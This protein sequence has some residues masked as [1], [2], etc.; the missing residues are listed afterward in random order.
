MHRLATSIYYNT[1]TVTVRQ[2]TV[3]GVKSTDHFHESRYTGVPGFRRV[4][5]VY[6]KAVVGTHVRILDLKLEI[7]PHDRVP[8]LDS[9]IT[10]QT[11]WKYLIIGPQASPKTQWQ[12]NFPGLAKLRV[13]LDVQV[14]MDTP[15]DMSTDIEQ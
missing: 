9:A 3:T 2:Y 8:K 4:A 1:H 13:V 6:P 15:R 14:N 5:F 11:D 10:S 12:N 7:D